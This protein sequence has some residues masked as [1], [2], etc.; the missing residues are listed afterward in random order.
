MVA[1]ALQVLKKEWKRLSRAGQVLRFYPQQILFYEG[2]LPYGIFVLNKGT[3]QCL[4]H[5]QPCM[6]EHRV[7][8]PMGVILGLRHLLAN[9]THDCTCQAQTDTDVLFISKTLLLPL[10]RPKKSGTKKSKKA[11]AH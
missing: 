5:G 7:T 10:L 11:K 3:V 9:T 6:T 1:E 2:H 4:T 8:T